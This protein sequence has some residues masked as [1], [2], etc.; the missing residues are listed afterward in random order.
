MTLNAVAHESDLL[1]DFSPRV[2]VSALSIR[3][4]RQ[5][6]T[7]LLPD[8]RIP[9]MADPYNQA[10]QHADYRLGD[11]LGDSQLGLELLTG[12]HTSL[13]A[14]VVGAHTIELGHPSRWLGDGWMMLTTGARL[15]NKPQVQRDLIVELQE[16]SASCLGFGVGHSFKSVPPALLDEA[17]KRDFPVVMVPEATQFRDIERAV[18]NSTQSVEASTFIR[19]SSLQRNLMRALS[20][21]NPLQSI[22]QRVGRVLHA[23]VVVMSADGQIKAANGTVP[24]TEIA[25]ELTRLAD[26]EELVMNIGEWHVLASR[27]EGPCMASPPWLVVASRGIPISGGLT[28]AVIQITAPLVDAVCRLSATTVAQDRATRESL[29]DSVLENNS[30][31]ADSATLSARIA[32]LGIGF[33]PECRAVVM[34]ERRGPADR[35]S[36]AAFSEDAASWLHSAL[37]Q[38]DV[39]YLLTRRSNEVVVV[40]CNEATLRSACGNMSMKWPTATVGVGRPIQRLDDVRDSY[41]DAHLAVQHLDLQES[42]NLLYYDDLDLVTQLLR[43]VPR[44]RFEAKAA[45]M[46]EVLENNPTQLEALRAY[47]ANNRDIKLAAEAIYL[48]PNT[49]RYRLDRLEQALGRSLREPSVTASLYCVLTLMDRVPERG[50]SSGDGRRRP[51]DARV[52]EMHHAFGAATGRQIP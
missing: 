6:P 50:G 19:L 36:S 46:V 9:S 1:D 20:D 33:G 41:R 35:A 17:R 27:V 4:A 51:A 43:E 13:A 45:S 48:H 31:A 34:R 15:R 29:L 52:V 38:S 16:A 37:E 44:E 3:D 30:G 42:R 14:P 21:A 40:L 39:P 10:V 25:H 18:S 2:G 24:A 28:A 26:S 7:V 11:L 8:N 47:F 32:A 12:S 5:S 49:L 22:L 23:T